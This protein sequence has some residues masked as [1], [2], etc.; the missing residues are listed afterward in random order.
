[1]THKTFHN[2]LR[3]IALILVMIGLAIAVPSVSAQKK[4]KPLTNKSIKSAPKGGGMV[5]F[6][7]TYLCATDFTG[8]GQNDIVFFDSSSAM[9]TITSFDGT[10][11]GFE[12]GLTNDQQVAADYDGDN[13]IDI[14]SVNSGDGVL[15][16]QIRQSSNGEEVQVIWGVEGDIPVVGD[17][18]GDNKADTA[19]LRPSDGLWYINGSTAGAMI[20]T[21][22]VPEDIPVPGDFDGDGTTDAAVF[23]VSER[24]FYFFSSADQMM[25]EQDWEGLF[26]NAYE[27]FVPADYDGD[28]VTDFAIFNSRAGVWSILESSTGN[29]RV[30]VFE[31]PPTLCNPFEVI[32]CHVGDYAFPADYDNDGVADPAVWNQAKEKLTVVGSTS[33]L[34]E[35]ATEAKDGM[36]PVSAYFMTE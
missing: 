27:T 30:V 31:P 28:G 29:Y 6:A 24:S 15:T 9:W 18:D 14:A 36:L 22:G 10:T 32:P 8:D 17:Y 2:S 23:R 5:V 35:R 1:M 33:G 16:W 7:P 12:F 25:H 11:S 13:I 4:T 19:V 20:L 34:E 26:R 21:C 3:H